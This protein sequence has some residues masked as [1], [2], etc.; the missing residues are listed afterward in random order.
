[1]RQTFITFVCMDKR[2]I[3]EIIKR[4]R[5]IKKFTQ[6]ELAEETGDTRQLIVNLEG[7]KRNISLD[8]L[9]KILRLIGLQVEVVPI[10]GNSLKPD[11]PEPSTI[12]VKQKVAVPGKVKVAKVEPLKLIKQIKAL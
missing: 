5:K 12:E 8:R 3:G 4:Y 10:D 7:G 2:Q 6:K 1:M 11:K 9:I